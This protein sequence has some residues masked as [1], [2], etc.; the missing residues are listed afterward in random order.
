MV[1]EKTRYISNGNQIVTKYNL[2][3]STNNEAIKI[4]LFSCNT[5]KCHSLTN[6]KITTSM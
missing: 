4:Y 1:S 3:S 2:Y 5:F 6:I